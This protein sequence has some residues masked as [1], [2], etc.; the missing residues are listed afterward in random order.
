[1]TTQPPVYG[2][3][4]VYIKDVGLPRLAEK[5]QS[6]RVDFCCSLDMNQQDPSQIVHDAFQQIEAR[7]LSQGG[8]SFYCNQAPEDRWLIIRINDETGAERLLTASIVRCE[9]DYDDPQKRFIIGCEFTGR[10]ERKP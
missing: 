6:T 9:K 10:L 4:F 2:A 8:L 7:D 5:R 3:D 1:M